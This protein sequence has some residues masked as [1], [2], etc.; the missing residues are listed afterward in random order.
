MIL[1]WL[2]R[3]R[4]RDDLSLF[5]SA[6]PLPE[7]DPIDEL[8]RIVG[9]AQEQDA[10]DERR[11]DNLALNNQRRPLRAHRTARKYFSRRGD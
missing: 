7:I 6:A 1:R 2:R 11:F 9:A 3:R 5:K 8:A 4:A 10:E